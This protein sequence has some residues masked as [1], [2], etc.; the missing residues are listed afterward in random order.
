MR[1]PH[2]MFTW[3]DA[4]VPDIAAGKAFYSAIFGWDADEVPGYVM[5]RRNGAVVAGMGR[6]SD[7]QRAEG[8]E[9]LWSSYVNVESADQVAN[10]AVVLGATLL[11]PPM[12][13]PG[14]GRMAYLADPGGARLGLWQPGGHEGAGSFNEEGDMAWNEL[15]TTQPAAAAEFYG[16]LLPWDID[17]DPYKM[18]ALGGRPNGGITATGATATARWVVYFAVG[19]TDAVA[20]EAILR[21]G[22]VTAGPFDTPFGRVAGLAD[23]QGAAFRVITLIQQDSEPAQ[24]GL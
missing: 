12:D 20:N 19:D 22:S 11:V 24:S 4:A 1:Y 6:L 14:A 9:P 15:L 10:H 7:E 17:G 2:G 18:I 3:T 21:G 16:Q 13:I 5:F 8:Y 23:D